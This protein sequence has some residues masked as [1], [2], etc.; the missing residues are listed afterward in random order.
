MYVTA[1]KEFL[2]FSQY[3]KKK[4]CQNIK[5]AEKEGRPGQSE[6]ARLCNSDLLIY[7]DF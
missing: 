2:R 1:I 4:F 3:N 6:V 5:R 7:F